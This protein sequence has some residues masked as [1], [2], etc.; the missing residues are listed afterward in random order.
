M[1]ILQ[2]NHIYNTVKQTI[3]KRKIET[4]RRTSTC[5]CCLVRRKVE[6]HGSAA[7]AQLRKMA[8]NRKSRARVWP[9]A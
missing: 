1:Y 8:G 4:N 5:K 9:R 7:I 6:V 3:A 2:F